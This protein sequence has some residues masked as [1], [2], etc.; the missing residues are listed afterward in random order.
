MLLYH[1]C[2]FLKVTSHVWIY[3]RALNGKTKPTCCHE[4]VIVVH[5]S[6][7]STMRSFVFLLLKRLSCLCWPTVAACV[8]HCLCGLNMRGVR[9]SLRALNNNPSAFLLAAKAFTLGKRHRGRGSERPAWLGAWPS[10]VNTQST[11]ECRI[12]SWTT[13]KNKKYLHLETSDRA[14]RSWTTSMSE[15]QNYSTQVTNKSAW[16]K[17]GNATVSRGMFA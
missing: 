11:P 5:I 17:S 15:L 13:E 14:G 9:V 8:Q 10:L 2:R 7:S 4:K 1:F 16:R 12:S 6:A 3:K